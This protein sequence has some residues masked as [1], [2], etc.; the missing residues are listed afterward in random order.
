[1]REAG[2]Y[3][4]EFLPEGGSNILHSLRQVYPVKWRQ[5]AYLTRCWGPVIVIT[6]KCRLVT[7]CWARAA[8]WDAAYLVIRL[9]YCASF[10]IRY[11][12]RDIQ[13]WKC[14]QW[15]INGVKYTKLTTAQQWA[16]HTSHKLTR[17]KTDTVNNLFTKK[18]RGS[19]L[20]PR[21]KTSGSMTTCWNITS[22]PT[23]QTRAITSKLRSN[24]KPFLNCRAERNVFQHEVTMN[25]TFTWHTHVT[26]YDSFKVGE[27][28][29]FP[30]IPPIR[31]HSLPLT[32][33]YLTSCVHT[34]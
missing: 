17:N 10:D 20:Q 27:P 13:L 26:N 15:S 21:S 7:N 11:V 19:V 33:A 16:N 12:N 23:S 14:H 24:C 4:V 8:V 5:S 18:T 28:M 6:H 29:I 22:Q 3:N 34:H 2:S 31:S 1:M 9:Q 25:R 32:V 30:Q